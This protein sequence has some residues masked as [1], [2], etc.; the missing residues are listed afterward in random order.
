MDH[1]RYRRF[2]VPKNIDFAAFVNK[3]DSGM[4]VNGFP[5]ENMHVPCNDILFEKRKGT[6]NI[7]N[8]IKTF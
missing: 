6:K 7:E 4:N 2:A 5:L 3:Q 1:Q 8:K